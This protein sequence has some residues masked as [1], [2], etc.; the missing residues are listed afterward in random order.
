M[1]F[2]NKAL[3]WSLL[4]EFLPTFLKLNIGKIAILTFAIR[5][6]AQICQKKTLFLT[7]LSLMTH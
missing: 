5:N 6:S 1:A 7:T 3:K 2:K 4:C